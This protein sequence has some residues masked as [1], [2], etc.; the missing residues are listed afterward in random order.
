MD[1]RIVLLVA[2]IAAGILASPANGQIDILSG[3]SLRQPNGQSLAPQNDGPRFTVQATIRPVEG[4]Q[5]A[6]LMIRAEIESG[7]HIY[8]LTQSP[9]GPLKT[10]INL[11]PSS[12]FRLLGEFQAIPPAQSH[13]YPDIW[14]GLKVEEHSGVVTWQAPI[15]FAATADPSRVQVRGAINAQACNA[16]ACLPPQNVHFTASLAQPSS[17]S[18]RTQRVPPRCH[19]TS[20]V[21]VEV[22][23]EDRR[24]AGSTAF[25]TKFASI[26]GKIE[27]SAVK[28]GGRARLTLTAV[29]VKP[30]HIYALAERDPE[31]V[32]KPTLIEIDPVADLRFERPQPSAPPIVEPS[33][34]PGER[35]VSFYDRPVT[36]TVEIAVPA[37]ATPGE[38]PISGLIGFQTCKVGSCD[39]PRG[40]RFS[41]ILQVGS[42][43]SQAPMLLTFSPENYAIVAKA[44]A[45][46]P[47]S[48]PKYQIKTNTASLP[49][50]ILFSLLGGLILNLMPC[51]LPVIGLKVLAF[52]EQSGHNRRRILLL[53][54]WYTAGMLLVFMVL[55]TLSVSLNLLWGQRSTGFNIAMCGLVFAMALSFLGVWEI[56]IPGFVGHGSAVTMATREGA[57]GAFAKGIFTTI[58]AT[59]CSGPFLGSVFQFTIGQPPYVTY[60][61][62][63]SIGLGMASPYLLIGAFPRLVGFLPKP[64]AWMETFKQLM[65]FVLL[66]TVVY[67]FSAIRSDYLVATF[68]LLVGIWAACWWIGRTPWTVSGRRRALAW[69]EAAAVAAVVGSLAF[70]YLT[71]QK[72]LLEWRPFSRSELEKLTADG[73]TVMLDFTATWCPNCIL[74]TKLAIDTRKV[75][76]L[77]EANHV[78]P[79]LADYSQYPPEV[80]EGVRG[81]VH[82]SDLRPGLQFLRSHDRR[83]HH[84]VPPRTPSDG[85]IVNNAFMCGPGGSRGLRSRTLDL[86]DAACRLRRHYFWRGGGV[87]R[88]R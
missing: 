53:N 35:M 83:S 36:W 20:P 62:F 10:K 81:P 52:V 17:T 55:A 49:V 26:Q 28:P 12:E 64:G 87:P 65:A 9:G 50:M 29:P 34:V 21:A 72:S 45:D 57:T 7:W 38:Y 30:W 32:S 18:R 31:I 40:A 48:S 66:G 15:E 85:C 70:T 25:Q 78:V 54:L 74:N 82:I 59:P 69:L 86:G 6:R 22:K 37:E 42:V 61:V 8:S 44:A 4:K 76:D 80:K 39:T 60:L 84:R 41:G 51:V 73:N 3:K 19:S 79:M 68:A 13:T 16:M 56:P 75:A 71:P 11:E 33:E 47:A 67:I 24:P 46:R 27:P 1:R 2:L 14:P 43:A 58:L 23:S 63:A 88:R 5:P 77:V